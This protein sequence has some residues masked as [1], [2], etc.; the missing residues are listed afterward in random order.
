MIFEKNVYPP[1]HFLLSPPMNIK[2]FY[3]YLKICQDIIMWKSVCFFDF[4]IIHK[5]CISIPEQSCF[6][7]FQFFSLFFLSALQFWN[8]NKAILAGTEKFL[9]K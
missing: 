9:V 6:F 5:S 4:F 7:E 2:Y 8:L 3:Y 1:Q